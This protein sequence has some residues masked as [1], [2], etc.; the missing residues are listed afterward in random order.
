MVAQ[1]QGTVR[2]KQDYQEG[3]DYTG[4][5]T[6]IDSDGFQRNFSPNQTHTLHDAGTNKT[7]AANA[8]IVW[9]TATAQAVAP[10]VKADIVDT[11]GRT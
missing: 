2:L 5:S 6:V 8:T 4:P 9:G 7:L 11:I 3:K 10:E 1:V